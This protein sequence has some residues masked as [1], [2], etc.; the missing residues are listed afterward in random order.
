MPWGRIL[1]A[2]EGM[3]IGQLRSRL[4]LV[5]G[6]LLIAAAMPLMGCARG[7]DVESALSLQRVVIYRNGV[8]YYERRGHVDEPG[9]LSRFVRNVSATFSPLLP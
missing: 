2:F 1:S 4:G 6:F 9:L 8:G 3:M 7:P 5:G